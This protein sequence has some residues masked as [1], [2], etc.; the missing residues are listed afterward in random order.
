MA[1]GDSITDGWAS[2]TDRNRRWPDYLARR[3]QAA[4]QPVKGVANAGISGNKV[5]ADGAGAEPR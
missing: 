2:S 1:L 5:L 3:L 4:R